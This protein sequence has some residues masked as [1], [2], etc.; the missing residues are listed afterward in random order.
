MQDLVPPLTFDLIAGGRS[1]LTYRV[2]DATGHAWVLRRPPLHGVLPSAHDVAREHR[3]ISALG[4]SKVPVPGVIG[5]CLDAEIS[6]APFFVMDVVP[7]QVIRTRTDAVRLPKD[8]RRA[9]AEDL[10]DV[11][12]TLHAVDPDGIGLGD[13]GPREDYVQR[14]LRRWHRQFERVKTRDLPLIDELRARLAADVPAQGS[15]RLVHGDYRLDN[16]I[17]DRGRVRAVLDWELSALGDPRADLGTLVTYWGVPGDDRSPLP[18]A[19]TT[20][21]GFPSPDWLVRRYAVVSGAEPRDVDFFV[22][23]AHWRLA[24]ILE[25]VY[26]RFSVGAYGSAVD[27]SIREFGHHVEWLAERADEMARRAGR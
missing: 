15:P 5:L 17:V 8:Q 25:G 6:G 4:S 21:A 26:A 9:V 19:P 7:G 16:L 23:F 13:L 10:V 22:A 20:A 18:D 11:L 12:A 1:N 24:V 3:I 2:A 14:Q 27:D